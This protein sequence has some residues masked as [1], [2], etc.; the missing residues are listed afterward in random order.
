MLSTK[1]LTQNFRDGHYNETLADIYASD[2]AQIQYQ[3]MRYVRA[4][5][6]FEETYGEAEVEIYSAPGRT[7]IGGNHT[8]HQKG[9]VLAASINLDAIAVVGRGEGA[10]I[11]ILSEG[12]AP[13]KISLDDLALQT[14]EEGTTAALIKGVAS[15]IK[16]RGYQIGA[17][18]AYITSDVLNGAG[19]SSSAAFETLIGTI[20]SGIFNEMKISPIEI[21]MIGQYAENVY[22]GKPCGLMDQ[23]ACSVGSLVHIDFLDAAHPVVNRLDYDIQKE[24]YSLC[25]VDTKGSHADLTPDYAAVPA[26][27]KSVAGYFDKAVLTEVSEED[28]YSKLPEIREQFGDR[29]VLRAMHFYNENRRVQEE[30]AALKADDFKHFLEV[31]RSSA[32]SS[33]KY[34]Q[35]VYSNQDV[36]SQAV[37]IAL[38][39][40]EKILGEHGVARVHGGGFAGTIQVFVQTEFV[41]KYKKQMETYMG[42]GT[43]HILH[44]RKYGGMKVC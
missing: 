3:T 36:K 9:M 22:F 1:L 18:R 42:E 28:F 2:E 38:A 19:M 33:Y 20:L 13:I 40:S 27:M 24:G 37:P 4:I 44:I 34:L 32:E 10:I 43:C 21:A 30:V 35:N 26:E 15:G 17:F 6:R 16:E 23:M 31:F 29:A 25:I 41:T 39:L 5:Q 8:D 12:Y 14:E 11:E 7:E